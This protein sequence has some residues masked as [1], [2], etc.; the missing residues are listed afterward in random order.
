MVQNINFQ[1]FYYLDKIKSFQAP[2]WWTSSYRTLLQ[3]LSYTAA[4]TL[5]FDASTYLRPKV[6]LNQE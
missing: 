5:D 1:A 3:I 4:D 6:L 2:T